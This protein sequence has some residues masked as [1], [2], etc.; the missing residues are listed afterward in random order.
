[1]AGLLLTADEERE[2]LNNYG[3]FI[4]R[5]IQTTAFED[6]L[7]ASDTYRIIRS[8]TD[9]ILTARRLKELNTKVRKLED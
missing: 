4:V 9:K 5:A 2:L 6:Q 8:A 7:I 1:M 3:Y